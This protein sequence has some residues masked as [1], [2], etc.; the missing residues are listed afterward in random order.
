[1]K[2]DLRSDEAW[3][4]H[5]IT[6]FDGEALAKEIGAKNFI[7]CSSKSNKNIS[8]VIEEVLIRSES[9]GKQKRPVSC[10]SCFRPKK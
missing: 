7:E 4:E 6:T 8:A 10:F 1:M 2:I 5:L 9:F 3:T